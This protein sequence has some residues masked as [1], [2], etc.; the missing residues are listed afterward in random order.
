MLRHNLSSPRTAEWALAECTPSNYVT[1]HILVL[2]LI[3]P[4]ETGF[5]SSNP[6]SV[7]LKL[8]IKSTHKNIDN[9]L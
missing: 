6:P 7:D 4:L 5:T 3:V 1:V 9:K 2:I 8:C